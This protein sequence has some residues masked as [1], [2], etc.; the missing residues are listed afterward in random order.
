MN[1]TD[2]KVGNVCFCYDEYLH[3]YVEHRVLVNSIEY[4]DA[5]ITDTNTF[6]MVC[7]VTDLD[8]DDDEDDAIGVMHEGNF[9]GIECTE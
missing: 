5:Y 1:F 7:Y 4:D 2:V 9:V 3:D 6:G 8:Y